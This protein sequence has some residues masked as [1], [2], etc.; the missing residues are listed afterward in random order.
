MQCEFEPHRQTLQ[1]SILRR[2]GSK[3]HSIAGSKTPSSFGRWH[4]MEARLLHAGNRHLRLSHKGC[5]RDE[6]AQAELADTQC[7]IGR[8]G[9]IRW[10]A[11]SPDLSC[12]AFYI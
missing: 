2:D 3:S 7:W 4:C 11:R 6:Y 10:P 1:K 9:Q 12:L 5:R 8:S